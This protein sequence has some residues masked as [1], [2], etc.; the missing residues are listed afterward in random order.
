MENELTINELAPYLPYGISY[1]DKSGYI[2]KLSLTTLLYFFHN[3]NELKLLLYHLSYL[4]KEIEVNGERFVPINEIHTLCDC[5]NDMKASKQEVEWIDAP[6][7]MC[8]YFFKHHFD[9]FGLIEKG[10]AIDKTTI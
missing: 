3:Q 2:E 4:T 6:Y 5:D 7:W 10:L 8:Q 1:I 9:V